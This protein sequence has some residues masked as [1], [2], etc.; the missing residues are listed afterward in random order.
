MYH[1]QDN[2]FFH[3]VMFHHFHDDSIHKIGQ[4]SI[5]INQFEKIIIYR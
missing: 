3:G 2:N 4:G 1:N 5:T